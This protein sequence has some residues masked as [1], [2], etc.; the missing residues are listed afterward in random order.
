MINQYDIA[1]SIGVG[2][3]APFWLLKPAAR[4]KVFDAAATRMGRVAARAG[5]APAVMIHAVSLG[6]I[7]ATRDLVRRLRESGPPGIQMIVS[8]TTDT[9]FARGRELYGNSGDVTLVRFPIDFS[10]AVSR[11]LDSLRPSLVVLMELEVWPN[12][13]RQCR[14]RGVPVLLINGRLTETSF[15]RYNWVRPLSQRMFRQLAHLCVQDQAYADRFRKLGASA[16]RLSVTGTM[17]FDTADVNA[18]VSGAAAL[19]ASVGLCPGREPI[20][21]CGSTG[22]G[23]EAILLDCYRKLRADF[24]GLRLVLV[25]RKPQRF[26][27]VADL[28][29]SA[30]F[31]CIRRSKPAAGPQSAVV[32]GDTMGEL[33]TWYALADVVFVGRTLLDL[34]PRQHGSDMI[35][36]AALAKPVIVGPYTGNFALPVVRFRM[37]A[38]MEAVN[39]AA[40]LMARIS[41]LLRDPARAAE[42]G[43]RARN[44]VLAEQGATDRH[45]QEILKLLH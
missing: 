15:R 4:R 5:S 24:P 44:V 39:N 25:P 36:P 27:E 43:R 14:R 21:V 31:D 34:G 41:A 37:A 18:D 3:S 6:E 1:Y 32:L 26:D 28:I 23:E 11:L 45:V 33:R 42:L 13:L 35:E 29:K 19:A 12:F 10:W 40:E 2:L 20:W 9:G 38:A 16:G 7:N 17:K 22:P 30:G 8:T